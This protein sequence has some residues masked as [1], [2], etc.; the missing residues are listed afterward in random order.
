MD[1]TFSEE[2]QAVAGIAA[3]VFADLATT[4][5]VKE[6]E[7]SADRVDRRLWEA[8]AAAG[9]VGIAVPE[10]AG[11]AGLGMIELCLALEQQGR[12][13]APVPLLWS[14]LGAMALSAF[15]PASPWPA[16]GVGCSAGS[17]RASRTPMSRRGCSP[18]P[19][20]RRGWWSSSST[21]RD[22]A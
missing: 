1:F 5:R 18:P 9:V 10:A 2:Q 14:A 22:R 20:R 4:E 11:G 21:R 19:G 7:R 12:R 6:V 8:L 3:R 15:T 17:A 13:V 16:P